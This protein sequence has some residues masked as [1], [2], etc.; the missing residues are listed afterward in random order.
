MKILVVEDDEELSRFLQLELEH[1]NYKVNLAYDGLEGL[2]VFDEYRPDMVILD[3]M[4][5]KIDGMSLAKKFREKDSEVGIIML[6]AVDSVSKKIELL[7]NYADDYMTKPFIIDELLA[8]IEAIRRRKFN[9]SD[10][11]I[12]KF[13]NLTLDKSSRTVKC[14]DKVIELSK[15][16]FELLEFLMENPNIVLSRDQ[17]LD[18][19]WGMDYFGNA[20]VVDVYINYVRKKLKKC[21]DH[22]STKRGMGYVFK[23]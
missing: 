15:K 17:I 13:K 5:P 1:Q 11:N 19:V 20:N 6:T 22:I 2:Q 12:L 21:K 4:L 8:R 16:E 23:P 18:N 9:H 14:E 3:I 10:S 7:K